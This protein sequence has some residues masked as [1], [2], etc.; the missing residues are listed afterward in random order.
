MSVTSEAITDATL[1]EG[2]PYYPFKISYRTVEGKRR[3]RTIRSPGYP[4]VREEVT[5]ML[6]DGAF[7]EVE[8]IAPGSLAIQEVRR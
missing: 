5:R 1:I 6:D 3:Q 2:V 7:G 8:H 4:W